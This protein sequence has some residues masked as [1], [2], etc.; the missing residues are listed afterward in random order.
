MKLKKLW[1][2]TLLFPALVFISCGKK[3]EKDENVVSGVNTNCVAGQVWGAGQC[4]PMAQQ[5]PGWGIYNN[6]PVNASCWGGA[7]M[8]NYGCLP[9]GRCSSG[10]AE[11]NVPGY[12]GFYCVNVVSYNNSFSY[13]YY[14]RWGRFY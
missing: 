2:L 8:T 11:Y 13:S 4:L 6:Q 1:L 7:Y 9:Q 10:L 5:N 12:G 3:D 14:Y